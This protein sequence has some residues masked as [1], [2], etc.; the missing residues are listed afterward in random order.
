MLPLPVLRARVAKPLEDK[1]P[2]ERNRDDLR[3]TLANA[4]RQFAMLA[5]HRAPQL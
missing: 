2:I 3:P 5:L 4:A 1:A